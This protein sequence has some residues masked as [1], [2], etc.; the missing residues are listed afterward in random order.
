VKPIIQ[1]ISP[2]ASYHTHSSEFVELVPMYILK[3]TDLQICL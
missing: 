1:Q 2:I 3:Q